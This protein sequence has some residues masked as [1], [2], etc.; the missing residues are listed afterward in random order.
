MNEVMKLEAMLERMARSQEQKSLLKEGEP[1][2][3][4]Q[5]PTTKKGSRLTEGKLGVFRKVRKET[6]LGE[7]RGRRVPTP[8]PR[9]QGRL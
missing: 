8:P 4:Q 5:V 7:R 1:F 2:R 6:I 9:Q 3:G